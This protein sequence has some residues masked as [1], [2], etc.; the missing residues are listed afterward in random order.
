MKGR[1]TGCH[2]AAV[3]SLCLRCFCFAFSCLHCARISRQSVAPDRQPGRQT[4]RQTVGDESPLHSPLSTWHSHGT[5]RGWSILPLARHLQICAL[6][7][8]HTRT[9]SVLT[10]CSHRKA[11]KQYVPLS[12]LPSAI[13]SDCTRKRQRVKQTRIGINRK[14]RK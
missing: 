12:S 5:L 1:G 14:C 13:W 9:V 8:S 4:G 7:H 6:T 2:L 3:M 11:Y 10:S